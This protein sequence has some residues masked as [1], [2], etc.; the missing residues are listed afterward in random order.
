MRFECQAK[1]RNRMSTRNTISA[2]Q[3]GYLLTAGTTGSAI[4]YIPNP[5]TESA[6]NG[7]WLSLVIAY[8]FG[9][10]LLAGIVYWY[11]ANN[12]LS[13][14]TYSRLLAGRIAAAAVAVPLAAMLLFAI[15]AIVVGISDFF[16]VTMMRETPAYVFNGITFLIAALTVRAGIEV[17]ARMFTVL[18]LIMLVFSII[19]MLL[20]WTAYQPA[21][22]LPLLPEGAKQVAHAAYMTAGFPFGEIVLYA[23]LLPFVQMEPNRSL[24]RCLF[25]SLTVTGLMLTLSTVCTIMAY[26]PSSGFYKYSLY[27]LAR[28]IQV[29]DIIQRVESV[30]GM[31]LIF[32]SYMKATLFLF[33]LDRILIEL[34]RPR[35][36]N[37][38]LMPITMGGLLLSQTMFDNSAD[39]NELVYVVWPFIVL[40]VSCTL[41]ALMV[42]LTAFQKR[43]RAAS[44][45][46][47]ARSETDET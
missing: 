3:M 18:V 5:L 27:M 38:F 20:A 2:A 23:M 30:I 33:I 9:M 45:L 24:P 40:I 32:G 21:F 41:I 44:N 4:V 7:A 8:G 14:V 12:G 31:A 10:L 13:P 22:L 28:E 42:L 1:M 36:K 46:A 47:A 16:T 19:V 25:G 26:G 29:Q 15:P 39:F 37:M 6:R 17:M 11:R 43:R 35:R 34:F